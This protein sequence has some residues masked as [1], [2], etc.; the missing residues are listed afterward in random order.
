VRGEVVG[1]ECLTEVLG[2]EAPAAAIPGRR[3]SG[4]ERAAGIAF[5]AAMLVTIFPWTRFGTGSEFP[6]AWALDVRWSM[7]AACAS[8]VGLAAWLLAGRPRSAVAEVAAI[9]SG[10]LVAAGGALAF[11][12]P[13]PFTKPSLA[14]LVAMVA[15][16]VAATTG[17]WTLHRSR[18]AHV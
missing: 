16:L 14:P 18:R 2:N 4:L 6:G 1:P 8:V 11:L 7:L 12:N 9:A 5:V 17:A 15:G 3:R 13:P 10:A